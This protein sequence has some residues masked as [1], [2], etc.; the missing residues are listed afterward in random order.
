MEKLY[1]VLNYEGLKI[2]Q[3]DEWFCFSLDSIILANFPKI[4]YRTNKIAELG[5]GNAI[6]PLILSRRTN[7]SIDA[8]EIQDDL[9]ILAKK[10]IEY[11]NLGNQVN[12]I[13]ADMKAFVSNPINYDKYDL[14]LSNPPYFKSVPTSDI[15]CNIH[16][17]IARHEIKITISDIMDG[18]W[19]IL[20]EGGIFAMVSRTDRFMEILQLFHDFRF[21]VK[22]IRFVH[23]SVDKS[24]ALFYVEA[25]KLGKSGMIIDKPFI[26]K[27]ALGNYTDEYERLQNEVMI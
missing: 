19:R 8:I 21:E 5:T 1:D 17:A 26:L 20:K 6:V 3:N 27:D 9:A 23:D 10:N 24:P 25:S 13:N 18:A 4:K 22:Y 7:S 14:V 16:K 15:N 2:Y 11:N 12:I